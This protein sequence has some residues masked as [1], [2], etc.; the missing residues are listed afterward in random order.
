MSCPLLANVLRDRV[1]LLDKLIDGHETAPDT[2]NQVVV[3][4]F[5][6]HLLGEVVVVTVVALSHE[7]A[8]HP[9]LRVR[10]VD[11]LGQLSVDR[12][13]PLADILEVDLVELVPVFDHFFKFGVAVAEQFHFLKI[14]LQGCLALG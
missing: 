9:L 2:Q 5:H 3:L 13:F 10:L 7:K 14:Y 11:E 8:L 6:D 1:V 4:N 12:I